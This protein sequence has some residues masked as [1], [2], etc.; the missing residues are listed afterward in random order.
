MQKN[1]GKLRLLHVLCPFW[2]QVYSVWFKAWEN[3]QQPLHWEHGFFRLKRREEAIM[4]CE[5]AGEETKHTG[6]STMDALHDATNAFAST[7][8]TAF[9][10]TIHKHA[11][12]MDHPYHDL[13]LQRQRN[14]C[15]DIQAA[16]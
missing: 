13:F 15:V 2:T 3:S 16:N 10:E 7:T 8:A 5:M 11:A 6:L 14:A 12:P 9:Q 1:N 4:I